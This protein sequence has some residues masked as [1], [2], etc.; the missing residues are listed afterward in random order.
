MKSGPNDA[1]ADT[2]L[3]EALNRE[4]DRRLAA[5]EIDDAIGGFTSVDYLLM[6][7]CGGLVPAA[8]LLWGWL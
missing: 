4:I 6:I 7:V 5:L 1:P 3:E 8:A 2:R